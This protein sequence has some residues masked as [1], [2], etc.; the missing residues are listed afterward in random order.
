MTRLSRPFSALTALVGAVVLLAACGGDGDGDLQVLD[1]RSRMSPMVTGVG[2]VYLDIANTTEVDDA[3]LGAR[4]DASVAGRVELHE[5][6]DADAEGHDGMDDGAMDD[7]AMGDG[8]AMMGMRE[9]ER[10]ELPTGATVR[11][12]PGGHHLMLLD[13]AED[14]VPGTE[15]D[16]TLIFA[17]AGEVTV[18]VEVREDV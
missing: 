1:P 5:T 17:E 12:V 15:F 9:V 4:V 2:A 7:D 18:T 14:L 6:F 11:L 13:L 8:S 3:L 10:L 16:L